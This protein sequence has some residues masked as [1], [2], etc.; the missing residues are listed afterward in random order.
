M[1]YWSCYLHTV[2]PIWWTTFWSNI[3]KR[4]TFWI[5][6]ATNEDILKQ[7]QTEQIHQY[8]DTE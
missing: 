8:W 5:Y 4:S 7:F 3:H 1:T 2:Y 6:L